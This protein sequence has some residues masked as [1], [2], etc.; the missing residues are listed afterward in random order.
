M[1]NVTDAADATC[2]K[3]LKGG[4]IIGWTYAIFVTKRWYLVYDYSDLEQGYPV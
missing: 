1:E 4:K 2:V 3:Y